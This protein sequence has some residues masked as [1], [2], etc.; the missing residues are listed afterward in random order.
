MSV[1]VRYFE[2]LGFGGREFDW[3]SCREMVLREG[4]EMEIVRKDTPSPEA[5]VVTEKTSNP[6]SLTK[7]NSKLNNTPTTVI[8]NFLTKQSASRFVRDF[9]DQ[10]KHDSDYILTLY[11]GS[12]WFSIG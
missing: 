7:V 2:K 12:E 1:W 9:F 8:S 6:Y 4:E 3:Q 5:Q 11:G 10:K